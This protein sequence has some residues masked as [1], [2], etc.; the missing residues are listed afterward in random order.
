MERDIPGPCRGSRK[1]NAN[2]IEILVR[3][4]RFPAEV[5]LVPLTQL[6]HKRGFR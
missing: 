6:K 5:I 1:T 3:H 2:P 4:F